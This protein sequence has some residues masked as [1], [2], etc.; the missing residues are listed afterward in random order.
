MS[1]VLRSALIAIV[2]LVTGVALSVMVTRA[3]GGQGDMSRAARTADGHPDLNG[4]WQALTTA[5]WDLEDHPARAQP[6]AWLQLGA[7]GAIPPGQGVVEGGQIPYRPEAAERKRANFE[8]RLRPASADPEA[9]CYLPGVRRATYLPFPFQIVQGTGRVAIVYG[10]A[11]ASRTIHM[12]KSTREPAPVDSWMG[13]SHGRWEGDTLV[14]ETT[15]FTGE[16]AFQNARESLKVTESRAR[17]NFSRQ[18]GPIA[19]SL[20][21]GARRGAAAGVRDAARSVRR[22]SPDGGQRAVSQHGVSP[23]RRPRR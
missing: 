6:G 13:R 9:R 10:F 3:A 11:D 17:G 20:A 2:G 4:L 22:D 5:N 21:V 23:R 18:R 19:E 12:D 7:I 1:N 8:Q 16:L 15:N 14:I